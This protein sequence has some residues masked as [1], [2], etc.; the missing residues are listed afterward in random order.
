MGH[1]THSFNSFLSMFSFLPIILIILPILATCQET[2]PTG[3]NQV[4]YYLE[5]HPELAS[6][7]KIIE[8]QHIIRNDEECMQYDYV[9]LEWLNVYDHNPFPDL[10]NGNAYCTV[11]QCDDVFGPAESVE[12]S[13]HFEYADQP[14]KK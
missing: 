8:D 13:L 3:V 10:I 5:Q 11:V 4:F 12:C 14:D 7:I 1:S 9:Y 6:S 2:D